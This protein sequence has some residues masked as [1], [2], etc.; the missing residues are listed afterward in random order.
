MRHAVVGVLSLSL[1]VGG[2]QTV[3]DSATQQ[4]GRVVGQA[5]GER[6][7]A[8]LVGQLP[9]NWGPDVT[10]L[11]ISH[12]LS[13]AFHSGGIVPAGATF[14]PGE[15][16]TWRV[17]EEQASGNLIGRAF[18]ERT[19]D[20]RE[21]WRVSM[22]DEEGDSIVAETLFSSDRREIRRMRVKTPEDERLEEVP[23][24]E[25]TFGWAPPSRL[26]EE[27]LEGATVGTETIQVPAGT[28]TARHVRYGTG[29]GTMEWWLD[30]SVPGGMVRYQRAAGEESWTAELTAFGADAERTPDR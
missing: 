7:G 19:D 3:V 9:A 11:Y 27:S 23:V 22:T 28:F 15:W 20:G 2:C 10:Q 24:Q 8:A 1:F 25:G 6:I 12:L 5:I 16:T 29:G 30:D 26:T 18:L 13:V 4:A 14:E 21:W 17:G